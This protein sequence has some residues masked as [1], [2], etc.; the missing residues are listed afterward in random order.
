MFMNF[1]CYV[2]THTHTKEEEEEEEEEE[3]REEEKEDEEEDEEEN[4]MSVLRRDLSDCRRV[5]TLCL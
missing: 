5:D 3:E 1:A 2:K 4:V